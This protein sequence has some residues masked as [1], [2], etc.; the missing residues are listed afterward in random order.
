MKKHVH[1]ARE[2]PSLARPWGETKMAETRGRQDR[3]I[4]W[5]IKWRKKQGI[6]FEDKKNW[7]SLPELI[8][9][10]TEIKAKPEL[11]FYWNNGVTYEL[12]LGIISVR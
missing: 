3:N 8:H 7:E 4:V 2:F 9:H 1:A 5:D 12:V 10:I 6:L 11:P